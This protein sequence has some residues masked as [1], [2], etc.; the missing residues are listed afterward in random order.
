MKTKSRIF[1][2]P[3][4]F[5]ASAVVALAAVLPVPLR[6]DEVTEW[7]QIMVDTIRATAGMGGINAARPAA[8]VQAAVFDALNG[9]ERRYGWIHVQPAAPSGASRRAAV[10]QAAYASLVKLFPAQSSSLSD[11]RA[12]SLA[13]IASSDAAE[14]SESI[15]RGIAWGQLVADA[16][17]AWR[18]ADGFTPAP[19]PNIGGTAAGQWRPTPPANLPFAVVQ[20]GFTTPWVIPSGAYFP[21]A[22]PP[23]LA[24]AK[25][26]AALEEVRSL[27][28]DT[29]ATRTPAQTL[30]ARFWASS[31]SPTFLWNRLAVALG[32]ERH[33]TLSE[34]A[35]ILALV[36]VAIADAGI[37]CWR[38][39][40]DY[41][42]WRPIT[43]IR[44][45]DGNNDWTPLLTTPPYPDYP[46][47]LCSLSAA[48]LAVLADYFGE[49]SAL[50]VDSDAAAMA[51]VVRSFT[52][53]GDLARE[54][55]DAR[56]YAG[57]HFRFADE[58][59]IRLGDEVGHFILTNAC[60]PLHGEKKGQLR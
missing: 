53:F 43:A 37:A 27:G 40:H 32:A 8:T 47:G 31:S 12:A 3:V 51:G 59:A 18:N 42:F 19:A 28:R 44:L 23:A 49:H 16:M 15:R 41:M 56:I 45:A 13:G 57:L 14:D 54:L 55:V 5:A 22:G 11:K 21:L 35:R 50:I 39:K 7:N 24:S 25:Y 9:V 29:S 26:A 10:V 20:L 36:N 60:L 34:N 38:A 1:A 46:S 2:C 4:R 33:T 58:D 17:V 30:I 6:A 52:N 48:A